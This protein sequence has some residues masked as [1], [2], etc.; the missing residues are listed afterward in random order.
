MIL[1]FDLLIIH[2]HLEPHTK[3][4][5]AKQFTGALHYNLLSATRVLVVA[6][7]GGCANTGI[8]SPKDIY[9]FFC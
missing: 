5:H 1:M 6:T 7:S 3:L 8:N 4:H 2:G 9:W